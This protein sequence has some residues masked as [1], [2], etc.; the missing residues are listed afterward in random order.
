MVLE[1]MRWLWAGATALCGAPRV[2]VAM[3][4]MFCLWGAV[5]EIVTVATTLS[6]RGEF[7]AVMLCSFNMPFAGMLFANF[8]N[9]ARDLRELRLPHRRPLLIA[10][11][12]FGVVLMVL[13]P[14]LL[15]WSWHTG[16]FDVLLVAAA[17]IAGAAMGWLGTLRGRARSQGHARKMAGMTGRSQ[18]LRVA[19]GPPYA[20]SSY[21]VRLTQFAVLSVAL[22]I[23]PVL[24]GVLGGSLSAPNFAILLHV[25][26]LLSFLVAMVLCWIWPLSRVVILFNPERGGL[27]ELALLPGLG[28]RDLRLRQL[29]TVVM[30]V[31]V[32]GLLV[33]LLVA[34][35]VARMAQVADEVYIKLALEFLLIPVVTLPVLLG[36]I[37]QRG[38]HGVW[39]VG[40]FMTTQIL[41]LTV[42]F[43]TLSA[44]MFAVPTLRWL[45][46]AFVLVTVTIVL[47]ASLHSL[48]RIARRPHLFMDVSL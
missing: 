31:P 37:A 38:A 15:A 3:L 29:C 10:A 25:A 11:M 6:H 33:L 1:V 17:A 26:E 43:W 30:T 8:L 48:R 19:L 14:S 21:L 24:V 2:L 12:A 41:A 45:I 44:K 13:A 18:V 46:V 9:L 32:A 16:R 20:P 23:A 34:L 42:L 27:S 40:F 39:S 4:V 28:A 35:A 22:L 36:Q 7:A 5:G 47:I